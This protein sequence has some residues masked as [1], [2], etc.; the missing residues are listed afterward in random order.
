MAT[1][2]V[3]TTDVLVDCI[4]TALDAGDSAVGTIKD[5]VE[6]VD[7]GV[8]RLQEDII[9]KTPKQRVSGNVS[10][11]VE[12]ETVGVPQGM[13]AAEVAEAIARQAVPQTV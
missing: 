6:E 11:S 1:A 3:L 2:G 7:A 13:T 10:L 8:K 12:V 4:K 9:A 5:K